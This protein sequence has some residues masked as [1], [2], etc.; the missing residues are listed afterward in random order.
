MYERLYLKAKE[1]D[2]D[3]IGCNFRHEYTD[4]QYVFRQQYSDSKEETSAD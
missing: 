1:T 3:I 4:I 2:A